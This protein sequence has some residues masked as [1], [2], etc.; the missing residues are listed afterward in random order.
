MS[1]FAPNR[2]LNLVTRD[3]ETSLKKITL[4]I[5]MILSCGGALSLLPFAFGEDSKSPIEAVWDAIYDLQKRDEQLQ[6]QIDDLRA[7]KEI[8]PEAEVPSS[9]LSVEVK[10]ES[11]GSS[12]E[13]IILLTVI[14]GG[15]D[16]AAGVKLTAFYLMPLF[17]INSIDSDDC[18]N[19]GRGII[20]CDL[21]TIEAERDRTITIDATARET[22]EQTSLTVDV[23]S[24]TEDA[25]QTNNHKVVD[26]LTGSMTQSEE[27]P[28]SVST[29]IT[30]ATNSEETR[31]NN[32]GE[33]SEGEEQDD[34]QS[35][36]TGGN[37]TSSEG[38][39]SDEEEDKKSQD[40]S[41][42]EET[43]GAGDNS[44]TSSDSSGSND[45]GS[46]EQDE[47]SQDDEQSQTT[48]G[49]QTSSDQ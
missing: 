10:V 30:N 25:A 24:T 16:R 3:H 6:T 45:E 17:Q 11:A 5:I 9:E 42:A 4:L 31:S 34:S 23:S 22:G 21:G 28:S 33:D 14:N 46:E 2:D 7:N 19:L 15:P 27:E 43:D 47:E 38:A 1:F 48:G 41:G 20:Q 36:A 8:L 39:S 32:G 12:G 18:R 37:Q 29:E 35:Q 44:Q 26:F 40:G 13:T 49:N